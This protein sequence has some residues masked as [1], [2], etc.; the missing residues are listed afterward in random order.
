MSSSEV[1]PQRSFRLCKPELN[2]FEKKLILATII[3]LVLNIIDIQLTLWGIRLQLI[4]EGNPLMRLLIEENP[5]YFTTLKVLL[6][7]IL[8]TACWWSRNTSQKLI[9]NG[10]SLSLIAYVLVML[11]HAHWIYTFLPVLCHNAT[12]FILVTQ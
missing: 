4:E 5:L 9:V 10:L 2:F 8:A 6:P 11:L 12:S 3:L 1:K 7:I